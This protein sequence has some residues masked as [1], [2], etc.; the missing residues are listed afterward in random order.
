MQVQAETTHVWLHTAPLKAESSSVSRTISFMTYCFW[1]L[2]C[3]GDRVLNVSSQVGYCSAIAAAAIRCWL[4][5]PAGG[6][7]VNVS[8][9]LGELHYCSTAYGDAI[10]GA[11]TVDELRGMRFRAGDVQKDGVKPTYW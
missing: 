9:E 10:M 1:H 6:R 5:T 3:A 2:A 8:S 11:N 4:T 7:I